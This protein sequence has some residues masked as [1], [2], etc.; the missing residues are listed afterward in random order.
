MQR[1]YALQAQETA[2]LDQKNLL[3]AMS[4]YSG[5]EAD[6]ANQI[7]L[8]KKIAEAEAK[9]REETDN[10]LNGRIDEEITNRD[11]PLKQGENFTLLDAEYTVKN[12]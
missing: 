3:A 7:A 5:T 1:K 10:A 2:I 11:M 6:Y 4:Q 9:A 12:I 8:T